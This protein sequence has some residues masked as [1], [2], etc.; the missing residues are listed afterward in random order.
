MI[1]QRFLSDLSLESLEDLKKRINT[2]LKFRSGVTLFQ[3]QYFSEICT[4][5]CFASRSSACCNREGIATFF[6]DILINV[7]FSKEKEI[8]ALIDILSRDRGGFKCI[9]LY[10]KGCMWRFKPIVC[11][12]FLCDHA[13][14]NVF[15]AAPHLKGE[16]ENLRLL[17]KDYTW[18]DKPVLFDELERMLILKGY[19]SPLMY[20]HKSPG[21]L[22]LKSKWQK[23]HDV[24]SIDE[25]PG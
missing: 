20:M 14:D 4:E 22:R 9:Y 11:E 17:E 3:E 18:P 25:K 5:K 15:N 24:K 1:A 12:M 6:A 10:E 21:L 23:P 7:L 13:L 8:H 19:D 2:Y 16:W